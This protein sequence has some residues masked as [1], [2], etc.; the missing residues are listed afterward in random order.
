MA[1][2]IKT[3]H[4]QRGG[5][6]LFKALGHPAVQPA[7]Q[8]IV[9]E[10]RAQAPIVVYDPHDY[11]DDFLALT[12]MQLAEI[13]QVY[14]Q[15]IEA[16]LEP[17]QDVPVALISQIDQDVGRLWALSFDIHREQDQVGHLLPADC[18]MTGLNAAR[19]PAE[20]LTRA[21]SYLDKLN[22]ATNFAF[23]REQAG[24][25][26]LLTT[27]NYWHRYGA[28]GQQLWCCL[29]DQD[30]Q[31]LARWQ[32]KVPAAVGVIRIDSQE[33]R[34]RFD[35]PE[36]CGQLFVHFTGVA[37]HEIVKYAVDAYG[38]D[39]GVLSVTHDANAWPS[40]YFAG[41]PAPDDKQQV[42]LWLQNS[43]PVPVPAG[44]VVLRVMGQEKTA[45]AIEQEIAPFA[46]LVLDVG[47]LMP[48]V[49]W[50]QQLEL[51]A[52]K[53]FVRPRYE[54]V[55]ANKKRCIAHI[56]VERT[57]LQPDPQLA[58]AFEHI[59]KGYILPAPILPLDQFNTQMLPTPMSRSTEALPLKALVYSQ[60]GE[61]LAEHSFGNLKRDH[62]SMLDV[63]ELIKDQAHFQQQGQY[64]HVEMV[65]D[66]E[67][68]K[69]RK[70]IQG[71]GWLHAIFR[72]Q[73]QQGHHAET[74]F[75]SHLFNHPLTFRNEPQSYAGPPPGVT[76]R[77]ILRL[78]PPKSSWDTWCQLI[79]PV[80]DHWKGESA[81]FLQVMDAK[82]KLLAEKFVSIPA[83]GSYAWLFTELVAE[84]PKA[85]K[86]EY[87]VISDRSCRLFGYHGL[88]GQ[89]GVFSLDH[90]FGA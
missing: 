12:G 5:A 60:A 76:T 34:K 64:G 31:E 58:K 42:L 29:F 68:V 53:Y 19:L 55:H 66:L 30:G 33:V 90:M 80:S 84:F 43:H 87:V 25:H 74:S 71:D 59:G 13:S 44:E 83:S 32:E 23:F 38:D 81:T 17:R 28:S 1:L 47:E 16:A 62:A 51:V 11:L 24:H 46:T 9:A 50:P 77:L 21:W 27:C 48:K 54:V 89:A 3:F 85:K 41:L 88:R 26:T 57:D 65:Y 37:G 8:Q 35:L 2:N 70:G 36:F 10:M 67:A 14:V 39:E 79:F 61:Q 40:D 7:L 72:Y 6:T 49:A 15:K 45:V 52:G 73:H 86:G 69:G 22:Y 82:G 56:N 63:S 78:A 75:G 18:E 20:L 4:P